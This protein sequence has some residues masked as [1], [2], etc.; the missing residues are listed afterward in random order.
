MKLYSFFRSGSSHRARIVLNLKNIPYEFEYIALNKNE[1]LNHSFENINPQKFV[2]VLIDQDTIFIQSPAMIE[3]IEEKYPEPALL[4]KELKEKAYV[5]A[6]AAMIGCDIHPINNKRVLEY[7]RH[8]LKLDEADIQKWCKNWIDQGFQ[9]LESYIQ[10][11]DYSG[12]YCC[13]DSITIAEAYLIPQI[14]SAIRFGVELNLYP[15][16]V[17]IYQNC[18]KLEEFQ[19]ASPSK[20]LDAF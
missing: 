5:R 2:P 9:A 18:M 1:H 3:W 20:Q 12:Q 14:D 13:G 8:D 10:Q 7:L 4:P 11:H 15:K 19:K 17:D 16:L 6:I